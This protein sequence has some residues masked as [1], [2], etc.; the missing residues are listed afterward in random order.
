[1]HLKYLSSS[2][3]IVMK[4]K[5]AASRISKAPYPKSPEFKGLPRT[6]TPAIWLIN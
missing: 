6:N 1:M 4:I 2:E 3:T 5:Q